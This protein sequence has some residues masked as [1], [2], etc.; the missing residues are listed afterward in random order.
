MFMPM[1]EQLSA[2]FKELEDDQDMVTPAQVG[3]IFVDWTDPQKA[4]SVTCHSND[5]KQILTGFVRDIHGQPADETIHVD[6][7]SDIVKALYNQ[8]M[9]SM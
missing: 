9:S 3:A 5:L 8:D 2:A 4:M 7:A 1:F 6:L